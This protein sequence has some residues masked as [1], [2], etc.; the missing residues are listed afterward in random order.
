[1]SRKKTEEYGPGANKLIQQD[2]EELAQS[3]KRAREDLRLTQQQLAR[4][5]GVSLQHMRRLEN[6]RG[7]VSIPSVFVIARLANLLND[8]TDRFIKHVHSREQLA[9][10]DLAYYQRSGALREQGLAFGGFSNMGLETKLEV[11]NVI[12]S[13]LQKRGPNKRSLR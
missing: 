8:S 6:P 2:L 7:I 9:D 13:S 12:K 1:L 3:V 11:L 4:R 10:A 5:L